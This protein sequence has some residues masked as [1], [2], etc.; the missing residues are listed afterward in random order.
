ML[1]LEE[2]ERLLAETVW[3]EFRVT[4]NGACLDVCGRNYI[5]LIANDKLKIF[6]YK[7]QHHR[8]PSYTLKVALK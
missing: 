5:R 4:A 6:R 1:D 7:Q 3:M 2:W 8:V